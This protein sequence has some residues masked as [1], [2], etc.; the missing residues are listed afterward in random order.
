MQMLVKEL[1]LQT[2]VSGVIGSTG[3]C[4]V[5]RLALQVN[6]SEVI[7]PLKVED[8]FSLLSLPHIAI[9]PEVME[10]AGHAEEVDDEDGDLCPGLGADSPCLEGHIHHKRP[11]DGHS[12][13]RP[14]RDGFSTEKELHSWFINKLHQLDIMS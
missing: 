11:L 14:A 4:L 1:A 12:N 7:D 5:K 10:I 6:V 3:K 8:V 2:N 13:Q 9:C